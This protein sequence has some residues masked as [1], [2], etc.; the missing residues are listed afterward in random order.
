MSILMIGIDFNKASLDIR[1][2]FSFTKK[3]AMEAMI[4]LNKNDNIRGSVILSTCNRM[5][6]WTSIKDDF[7]FDIYSFLC[8]IKGYNKELYRDFFF[9]RKNDEA[10]KHLF[11]MTAGLKSQIIGED[12]IVSQVKEAISL[13]R[14]VYAAD[15]VMEV[16]FR[17]A[18][19]AAKKVKTNVV[20][21]RED[22][23]VVKDCIYKLKK[24]GLTIKNKNIMVIG[25]GKM[26][27][28]SALAFKKEGADV[29]V[30]VR[31]HKSGIIVIPKG[32]KRINYD[33]REKF[34]SKTD[35]LISATLSPNCTITESQF[36]KA[37]G[38]K[39]IILIDFAVPR[40][41]DEN[42]GK[43]E[44]AKLYDIDDFRT[45]EISPEMAESV[46]KAGDILDE[47][48]DKFYDWYS[49]RAVVEDIEILKRRASKDLSLR[50]IKPFSEL[51]IEEEELSKIKSDIDIAA[52]KV[53]SKMIFSLRD[54]LDK[55]EFIKYVEELKDSYEV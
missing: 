41:I 1:S 51:N 17:N 4:K 54:T 38:G 26:G 7:D 13:S 46:K 40:D 31:Q 49:G 2:L 5:E 33:D 43:L 42:I 23:S 3:S 29:T 14:K 21:N 19:T 36:I 11:Y 10:V 20:F 53:V 12:Q 18:I 22:R 15:N 24:N 50:L 37:S 32:C 35:I 27:Q 30:T 45:M 8:D 47:N 52:E 48:I 44:N 28:I 16:L 55:D 6:I 34:L 9:Y 39:D 25:N